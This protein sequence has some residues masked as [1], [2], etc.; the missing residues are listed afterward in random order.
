MI[1][2]RINTSTDH[3][4]SLF[5]TAQGPRARRILIW[6]DLEETSMHSEDEKF[7]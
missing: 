4:S 1:P 5:I 7:Y 3:H 2:L 6:L